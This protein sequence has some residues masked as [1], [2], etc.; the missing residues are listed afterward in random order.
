MLQCFSCDDTWKIAW[1]VDPPTCSGGRHSRSEKRGGRR[2][3]AEAHTRHSE[4]R[5]LDQALLAHQRVDVVRRR[6]RAQFREIDALD[7]GLAVEQH[8]IGIVAGNILDFEVVVQVGAT[9]SFDKLFDP[10]VLV[11]L[12][13]SAALDL[14]AHARGAGFYGGG[15]HH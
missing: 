4:L 3:G 8:E 7:L 11:E 2:H 10:G 5:L 12:S 13:S 15:E 9:W 14:A 1:R 6:R